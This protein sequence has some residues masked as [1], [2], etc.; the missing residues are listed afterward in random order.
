MPLNR[1]TQQ[2]EE[3]VCQGCNLVDTKPEGIPEEIAS[4]V[5]ITLQ[6]SEIERSGGTFAYPD[7]LS[8]LEW[9]CVCGLTR[10]RERAQG[11]SDER[12]RKERRRKERQKKT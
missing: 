12:D 9:A 11:L 3:S 10:G 1:Y 4:F 8:S 6:I 5:Q 7:A 2:P